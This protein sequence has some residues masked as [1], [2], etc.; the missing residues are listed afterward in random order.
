MAAW[1][2]IAPGTNQTGTCCI[3][4]YGLLKRTHS[5]SVEKLD[6]AALNLKKK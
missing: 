2:A 6:K 1:V 4:E 5:K 3:D